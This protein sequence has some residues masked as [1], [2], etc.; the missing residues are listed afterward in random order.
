MKEGLIKYNPLGH[1]LADVDWMLTMIRGNEEIQKG[2]K[3]EKE[4]KGDRRDGKLVKLVVDFLN[5]R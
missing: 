2:A 5:C 4:S 3:G 1:S